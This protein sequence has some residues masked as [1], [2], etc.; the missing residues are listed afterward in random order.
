[1]LAK[2]ISVII[3]ITTVTLVGINTYTLERE[4]GKALEQVD[5]LTITEEETVDAYIEAKSIY[6]SFKRQETYISLTVDHSDLMTIEE[7]FSEMIGYLSVGNASD[8][9]VIKNRLRDSL[10]HL[11][12][13]SGFNIDSII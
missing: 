6:E 11:R 7:S 3:F 12:R 5:A 10:E 1:M 2:I 13:L 8:A 4:I 9:I